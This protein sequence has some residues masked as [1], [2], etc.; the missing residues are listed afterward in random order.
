MVS[1]KRS[2]ACCRR[3]SISN[4]G[5]RDCSTC[6]WRIHQN[7]LHPWVSRHIQ[8]K[9]PGHSPVFIQAMIANL[10]NVSRTC[11]PCSHAS[12]LTHGVWRQHDFYKAPRHYRDG[13]LLGLRRQ[14]SCV[15]ICLLSCGFVSTPTSIQRRP[16]SCEK[17]HHIALQTP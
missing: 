8:M 13:L 7:Y 4:F 15:K 5:S 3:Q 16:K 12:E 2:K 14:N 17:W 11:I 9:G 6:D 10:T 1:V